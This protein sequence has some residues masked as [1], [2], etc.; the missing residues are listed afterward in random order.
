MEYNHILMHTSLLGILDFNFYKWTVRRTAGTLRISNKEGR[1]PQKVV[2]FLKGYE[3]TE[4]PERLVHVIYDT[5]IEK[6]GKMI[7]AR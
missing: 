2:A 6:R 1:P 7:I 4:I 5:G 3:E